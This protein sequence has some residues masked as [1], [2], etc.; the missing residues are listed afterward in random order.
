MS[1]S[2]LA[3]LLS[4]LVM[5]L[6]GVGTIVVAVVGGGFALVY[7]LRLLAATV[8][9]APM[10]PLGEAVT[11]LASVFAL[12]VTLAVVAAIESGEGSTTTTEGHSSTSRTHRIDR[13]DASEGLDRIEESLDE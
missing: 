8:G 3:Q 5:L 13:D 12:L 4:G 11:A 1:D 7:M 9:A 6:A 10:P 2:A